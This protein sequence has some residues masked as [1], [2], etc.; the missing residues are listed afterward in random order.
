MLDPNALKS[1]VPLTQQLSA[2]GHELIAIPNT[3]LQALVSFIPS[4]GIDPEKASYDSVIEGYVNLTRDEQHH[5]LACTTIDNAVAGVRKTLDF[6]RNTVMPHI[7]RVLEAHSNVMASYAA[8]KPPIE[9]KYAYLPEIY[10]HHIARDLMANWEGLPTATS[11]GAVNLG[12]Y[13]KEEILELAKIS[14][15]EAFN[16]DLA[17]LLSTN[18]DEG[19]KQII[20]VLAGERNV[21]QLDPKY[22][23]P[24]SIVLQ[25]IEQPKEGVNSTLA[26]YNANRGAAAT[27]AGKAAVELIGGLTHAQ[28]TMNVYQSLTI[29]P[30][31]QVLL[32]GE[33][34][35]ELAGQGLTN[36]A[37]IGNELMGRPFR[38][39]DLVKPENLEK[40]MAA[41]EADRLTRQQ[42]AKIE[43]QTNSRKAIMECLRDDL[44]A[45]AEKGDFLIEGDDKE[46]AWS[47]LRTIV[48]KILA[49]EWKNIEPIYII[50]SALCVTWYAHTDAARFIDIML[51]V[52]KKNPGLK[53][54][55][56]DFLA[57]LQ[58]I[59]T[60][61]ASMVDVQ[62]QQAV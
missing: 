1:V 47:R 17:D 31:E 5:E 48:D 58:Y 44:Y 34:F 13:E 16:E 4:A 28:R 61:V 45:M 12:R 50:A 55:E 23:L 25:N 15:N 40:M 30:G 36:E 38:G 56:F 29:R 2:A 43:Q 51:D 33:V 46:R 37:M 62:G 21:T 57:T 19:Y 26:I 14:S 3:P 7:R 49:S 54:T 10:S 8:G 20:E 59:A 27:V 22:S 52:E 60:W 53:E 41:Y 11:P 32:N 42:A 18:G 35:K 24:A 9:F 39:M 6:T